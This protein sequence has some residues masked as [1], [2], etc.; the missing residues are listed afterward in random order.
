MQSWHG[1]G[2][3]NLGL[4]LILHGTPSKHP[5]G[6]LAMFSL[7]APLARLLQ[8]QAAVAA[9]DPLQ[10]LMERAGARAGHDPHEARELREAAAAWLRVIR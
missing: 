7:L 4:T 8:P 2:I 1:F 10:Q 3:V 5:P 9:R 6:A